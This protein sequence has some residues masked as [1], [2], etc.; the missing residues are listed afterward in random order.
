MLCMILEVHF[1]P[2]KWSPSS[3]R[4]GHLS[5]TQILLT[6]ISQG[7]WCE[8]YMSQHGTQSTQT[9]SKSG[10]YADFIEVKDTYIQ[11]WNICDLYVSFVLFSKNVIYGGLN[12]SRCLGTIIAIFKYCRSLPGY[13]LFKSPFSYCQNLLFVQFV[14]KLIFLTNC[15][16]VSEFIC[17]ETKPKCQSVN[18][19]FISVIN[20]T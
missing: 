19:N 15:P 14:I 8:S 4:H 18:L 9:K 6:S 17:W 13:Q 12:K 11:D 10:C 7:A 20:V 1:H 2:R 3:H 5:I 16:K